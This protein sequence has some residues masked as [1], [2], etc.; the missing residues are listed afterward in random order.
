MGC[1]PVLCEA[2]IKN[3]GSQ[4][5]SQLLDW[6]SDNSEKEAEWKEW[7]EKGGKEEEKQEGG[8]GDQQSIDHLVKK[9]YVE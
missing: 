3:T 4:D 8:A 6:I 9:E 1:S 5:L 2:A 7:L